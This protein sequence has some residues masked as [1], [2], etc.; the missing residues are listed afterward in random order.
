MEPSWGKEDK[1]KDFS[2]LGSESLRICMMKLQPTNFVIEN[3]KVSS[4]G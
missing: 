4:L 1:K 3:I 2:G